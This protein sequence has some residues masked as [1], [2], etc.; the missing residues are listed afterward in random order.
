MNGFCPF[1]VQIQNKFC[2]GL[3]KSS[4][5]AG[6][7]RKQAVFGLYALGQFVSPTAFLQPRRDSFRPQAESRPGTGVC[8]EMSVSTD[9]HWKTLV[10][11][12][13][14]PVVPSIEVVPDHLWFRGRF[15]CMQPARGPVRSTTAPKTRERA[16]L[17]MEAKPFSAEHRKAELSE[18][19]WRGHG[20][21]P[22]CP[23]DQPKTAIGRGHP[24]ADVKYTLICSTRLLW[25]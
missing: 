4:F 9:L 19:G 16:A 25:L 21:V 14:L 13:G 20:A 22:T 24:T 17:G 10:S 18:A 8:T 2:Q 15:F 3:Q 6:N 23:S 12:Q 5:G 1:R 11:G 7:P